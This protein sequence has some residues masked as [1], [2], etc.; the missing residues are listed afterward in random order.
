MTKEIQ[1]Y[2]SGLSDDKH[3]A[4]AKSF[5]PFAEEMTGLI[6]T[7]GTIE[8][9]DANDIDA[10][11]LARKTRLELRRV[12]VD[13]EKSRKSLKESALRE[14]KAID[15]M[16]NIIKFMIVPVEEALQAKEDF[17]RI[18]E[19]RRIAAMV[20][21]RTAELEAVG[22]D[23]THLDLGAMSDAAYATLYATAKAGN[24]AR[25]KAE[26]EEA[27][28]IEADRIATEK[29]DADQRKKDAAERKQIE[30][31]NAKLRKEAEE[32]EK[33]L[34]AERKKEAAAQAVKD[35]KAA[36]ERKKLEAAQAATEKK[37]A[38]ERATAKNLADDAAKAEQDRKDS[39]AQKLADEKA[40]EQARLA[41][42]DADKLRA[43]DQSICQLAIPSVSGE[44][45]RDA[46]TDVRSGMN[47]A[48]KA[49]REAINELDN[50][51][52]GK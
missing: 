40:A 39:E 6:K 3:N 4:L 35:K 36:A 18:A 8:V 47:E 51:K 24:D 14:G 37:L 7:A 19:K 5:N 32:R 25:I 52:G 28:R 42:P 16:A 1:K 33:V 29:A 43:L 26:K 50:K 45:A 22:M 46:I 48:V 30:S 9:T 11:K 13:V 2:E 41:A 21:N 27:D 20:D 49:I 23:C 12:R 44:V 15:G 17:V 34:A 38:A 31:D 10:M